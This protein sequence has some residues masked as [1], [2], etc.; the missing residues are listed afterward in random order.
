MP[1][2]PRINCAAGICCD[3]A[4][5]LTATAEILC[6]IGV[7]EDDAPKMA[8]KMRDMGITFTSAALA[9]A[10]AAIADHPRRGGGS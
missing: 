10:V 8:A 6:D 5:A 9:E 2:D 3:P 4:G 7:P 1:V